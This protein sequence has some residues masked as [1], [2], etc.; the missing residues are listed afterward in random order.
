[1]PAQICRQGSARLEQKDGNLT[2]VEVDEVLGLMGDIGAEVAAHDAMPGGVVLFV[3]FL[4]DEGSDVLLNVVALE[5]VGRDVDSVLLHVLGHVSVL[6]DGLAVC[7]C[8]L[9]VVGWVLKGVL[10]RFT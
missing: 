2:K 9:K 1:M 5:G 4:L 10:E 6:D 8:V 7:H 3:E